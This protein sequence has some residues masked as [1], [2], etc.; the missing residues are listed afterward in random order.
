MSLL[1][2]FVVTVLGAFTTV[3]M[4]VAAGSLV[5]GLIHFLIEAPGAIRQDMQ[6]WRETHPRPQRMIR[7]VR[8]EAAD[9]TGQ[10]EPP[11]AL[12]PPDDDETF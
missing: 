10:L 6:R 5:L 9:A 2:W 1:T 12:P 4:V 11:R 8:N 3:Y 7:Y